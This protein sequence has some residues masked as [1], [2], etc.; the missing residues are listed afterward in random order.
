[1]KDQKLRKNEILYL[2]IA[3]STVIYFLI[4]Y[5]ITTTH[6][7]DMDIP[8][9][10]ITKKH[11]ILSDGTEVIVY[12]YGRQTI[13]LPIREVGLTIFALLAVL[14]YIIRRGLKKQ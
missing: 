5:P 10:N 7:K 2:I 6:I 11:I 12:N 13:D 4:S 1:M 9:Q 3:F 8:H 14:L